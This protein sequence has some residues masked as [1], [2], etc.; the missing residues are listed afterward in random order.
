MDRLT[1]LALGPP[2]VSR[3]AWGGGGECGVSSLWGSILSAVF[4]SHLP[5]SPVSFSPFFLVFALMSS[6]SSKYEP[7]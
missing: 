7:V 3:R 6:L 4:S 5:F 2:E 1:L